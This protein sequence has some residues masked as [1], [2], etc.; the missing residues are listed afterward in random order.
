MTIPTPFLNRPRFGLDAPDVVRNLFLVTVAGFGVWLLGLS[1]QFVLWSDSPNP[2]RIILPLQDMGPWVGL[3]CGLTGFAMIWYSYVGKLHMRERL[4]DLVPWHGDERVLDV[5]CGR[6]LMLL[7]VAARV[8]AGR[9]TGIDLWQ[10]EDLTG[11]CPAATRANAQAAGVADRVEVQT[12]DA[13]QLPFADASFDVV[14]ST[15]AL[16]NIY[17]AAG[18]AQA[19]R[20]IAR[21]LKPGGRVVLADMRH[22]RQYADVLGR[23]GLDDIRHEK[24]FL[25]V[26]ALL[27]TFGSVRPGTVTA[28]KPL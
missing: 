2:F 15:A 10:G 8:P 16:H 27:L 3:T 7:G 14:V 21:V 17:E 22:T 18:R 26:P 25:A 24:G 13:R 20:E 19:V 11:N 12:G 9:V 4:L 28:H 23:S 6:G 5:G 1:L